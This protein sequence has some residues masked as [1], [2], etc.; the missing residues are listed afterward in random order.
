MRFKDRSAAGKQLA[1]HLMQYKNNPDA[2]VL[3]LPRGG[4]VV[5]Y[6][7]AQAL[8]VPLDIIVARKI[9][10]PSNSELAVGALTAGGTTYF[11]K[12]LMETM[13]LTIHELTPIIEEQKQ[14]ALRRQEVYRGSRKSLE[15]NDKIAIIVDDGIATGA[16]MQAAVL[17]AHSL[18]AQSVIV[19][20]PVAPADEIA[21]FEKEADEVICLHAAASFFGV[22]QFYDNFEQVTDDEVI[23]LLMR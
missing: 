17:S 23:A 16:T 13:G 10:S 20:V 22:G 9:G 11:N 3:G 5:A 14:E 1:Q 2:I 12:P 15:L 6:E 19:A 18:G 7:V 21:R 8:E 4:V